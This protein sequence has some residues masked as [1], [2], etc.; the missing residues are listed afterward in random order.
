MPV[1]PLHLELVCGPIDEGR[2]HVLP[3]G[4]LG[5]DLNL[6][7]RADIF[8]SGGPFVTHIEQL[9][10]PHHGLGRAFGMTHSFDVC[11][12]EE[13]SRGGLCMPAEVPQLKCLAVIRS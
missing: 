2:V 8:G 3:E 4:I 10:P 12:E 13:V 9:L 6:G 5:R 7:V 11:S 1:A